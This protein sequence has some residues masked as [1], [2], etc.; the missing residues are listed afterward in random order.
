MA[1]SRI[2]RRKLTN[3]QKHVFVVVKKYLLNDEFDNEYSIYF[4]YMR[5][6]ARS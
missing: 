2:I 5:V 4:S 3:E 6:F 1:V